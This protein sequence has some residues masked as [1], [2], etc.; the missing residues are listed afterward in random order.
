MFGSE[1]HK[2]RWCIHVYIP[3]LKCYKGCSDLIKGIHIIY[4]VFDLICINLLNCD[5][6]L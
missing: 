1:Y 4:F 3:C 5:V 2:R 6:I